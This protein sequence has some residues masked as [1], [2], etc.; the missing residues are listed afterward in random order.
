MGASTFAF[1]SDQDCASESSLLTTPTYHTLL[2]TSDQ[3]ECAN[4]ISLDKIE[5]EEAFQEHNE[6]AQ[7][8]GCELKN[9]LKYTTSPHT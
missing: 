3:A 9:S 2:Y 6:R 1:I 7:S 8:R 5:M 4:R